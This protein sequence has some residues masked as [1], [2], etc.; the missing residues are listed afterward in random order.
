LPI[1]SN[2]DDLVVFQ[3]RAYAL[4]FSAIAM[5]APGRKAGR[6]IGRRHCPEVAAIKTLLKFDFIDHGTNRS[7]AS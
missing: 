4:G 6:E 2:C 5:S 1:W 7:R 3:E